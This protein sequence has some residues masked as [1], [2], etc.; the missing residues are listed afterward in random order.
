M[1]LCI[2]LYMVLCYYNNYLSSLSCCSR[3]L[4]F[5]NHKSTTI[6]IT[7]FISSSKLSGSCWRINVSG[8]IIKT[9]I[10]RAALQHQKQAPRSARAEN[11]SAAA[12]DQFA[13]QGSGGGRAAAWGRGRLAAPATNGG[14]RDASDVL[15]AL[16]IGCSGSFSGHQAP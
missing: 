3:C 12:Q 16:L 4:K 8:T 7:N 14:E 15:S 1:T 13:E 9:W 6:V 11:P 10:I 2:V 5:C